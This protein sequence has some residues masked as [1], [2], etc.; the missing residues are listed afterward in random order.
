MEST[1]RSRRSVHGYVDEPLSTETIEE[2]FEVARFAPSSYNL[3]PWEYLV[4]REEAAKTRLQECAYGQEHV[5]DAAATV[6][7]LGNL[8][9]AAHA[10]RVF[11]DWLRKEY[12]PEESVRD[13]LVEMARN[14]RDRPTETNRIWTT[15][16]AALGAMALMYAAWDR[17]IASCPMGGFDADAVR[18]EFGTDGY[19][20]VMLVT[21]GY[22]DEDCADLSN[23]RKF[24]RPVEEIVHFGSFDP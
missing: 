4:L 8:D 23:D 19:E 16:S 3:Q 7:V 20:P 18:E 14:W 5:T 15:K 24:R 10:D 17:G 2:I 1:I 22:P 11:D 21:L 12:L 6:V 13:E 9:P